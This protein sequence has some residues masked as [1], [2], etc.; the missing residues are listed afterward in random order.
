MNRSDKEFMV[1]KIRTQ[2]MEKEQ[3]QLDLL[4][5]LDARVK[6]PAKA[7]AYMFGGVGALVMGSGMSLVMTDIG[8]RL[9]MG[10]AIIPGIAIGIIGILMAIVNVPI[11]KRILAA[12]RKRF[13]GEIRK[14]SD[15]IM[16]ENK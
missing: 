1:E 11:Y 2:Y 7:F 6:R 13:A 15:K 8:S 12:R 4:K 16:E 10:K 5:E 3:T 9:G 14:L